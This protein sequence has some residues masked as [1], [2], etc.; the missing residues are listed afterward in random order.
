MAGRLQQ[1]RLVLATDPVRESLQVAEVRPG[2][3]RGHLFLGQEGHERG[4][5]IIGGNLEGLR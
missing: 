2:R 1:V 4:Q 5:R 3:A